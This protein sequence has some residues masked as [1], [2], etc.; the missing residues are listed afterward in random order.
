VNFASIDIGTNSFRILIARLQKNNKLEYLYKKSVITGLGRDF[1][2]STKTLYEDSISRGLNILNEFSSALKDYEVSNISAIAT[3]VV[4]ES[5][6]SR[7]FTD[8]AAKILNTD[9]KVISGSTEA[10]LTAIGV[11]KSINNINKNKLIVDIG[12]GSTE[13]A[14][15]DGYDY[16]NSLLSIEL[17]VV[18]ITEIFN[19]GKILRDKDIIQIS[20][21]IRIFIEK[22]MGLKDFN[23]NQISEIVATAG[24]P[25]TLAAMDLS[26][27]EYDHDKVN[28]H[29][30]YKKNI[31]KIFNNICSLNSKERLK[32]IGLI[33][34]RENLIIP[35]TLIILY[36]LHRY[37]KDKII[38]S[39]GGMLEGI[40]YNEVDKIF[41]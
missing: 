39:D 4:R 34:G 18:K 41:Q 26:L 35:G 31:V 20:E 12:G 27:T 3:S 7:Q 38:V 17:G 16:I 25:T 6:N 5:V 2:S 30:L 9:I 10:E 24:T 14:V 29:I 1:N 33:E 8:P 32:L 23:S 37:S 40:I 28:G 11:L 22:E 36:L 21:H 15:V 13:F 19:V